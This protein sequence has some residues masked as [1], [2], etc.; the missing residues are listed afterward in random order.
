VTTINILW[1]FDGTLFDTYPIYAKLFKRALHTDVSEEDI[2]SK[3]KISFLEAFS[4][5][6]MTKEQIGEFKQLIRQYPA[7]G[8]KPFDSVEKVLASADKN[9]I[10]THNNREDLVRILRHYDMEHYFTE[11]VTGDDGFPRKPDPASYIYLDDRHGIDLAVGDRTLDIIPAKKLG[12]KT[13][14]F[15]NKEAGADFYVDRY[16]EFFDRVYV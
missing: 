15:Q 8:F 10:M 13:C 14:L 1:D 16:D 11:M 4:Y 3:I 2:F 6:D 12:K 5:F 9:V 7:S